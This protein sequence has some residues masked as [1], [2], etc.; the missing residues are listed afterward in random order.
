M[1]NNLLPKIIRKSNAFS[2]FARV[3]A[4][5]PPIPID[6]WTSDHH[7]VVADEIYLH[8]LLKRCRR[9]FDDNKPFF[10][11]GLNQHETAQEYRTRLHVLM[12][13]LIVFLKKNPQ[14]RILK[15]QESPILEKDIEIMADAF[16]H[17]L[18]EWHN[19]L[20]DV[21][22][23]GV[24]TI[25]RSDAS[26]HAFFLDE[27]SIEKLG[28]QVHRCRIFSNGFGEKIANLHAL[29]G[30]KC[31]QSVEAILKTIIDDAVSHAVSHY[32]VSGDFNCDEKTI[33]KILQ[34]IWEKT[35]SDLA[36]N[37][38]CEYSEN[39]HLKSD[40]S[41]QTTDCILRMRFEKNNGERFSFYHSPLHYFISVTVLGLTFAEDTMLPE[42]MMMAHLALGHF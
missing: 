39:G 16:K 25:I 41:Y 34:T 26:Q 7:A 4:G 6:G 14:V 5:I 13:R 2:F 35:N 9:S 40:G 19:A 30:D 21:S 8:N 23:A 29:Y 22:D 12:S 15:F 28:E 17:F 31:E 20:F 33:E 24:M 42:E 36:L 10:N 11:N 37:V 18:P 1:R 27:S 3:T 38:Q 32:T